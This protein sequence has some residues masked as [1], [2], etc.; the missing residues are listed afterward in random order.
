MRNVKRVNNLID[1][2]ADTTANKDLVLVSIKDFATFQFRL[3]TTD[4]KRQLDFN[5][6]MPKYGFCRIN[7]CNCRD[8]NSVAS[9]PADALV[10]TIKILG[11]Q[12]QYYLF[13]CSDGIDW[14]SLL[15]LA[16]QTQIEEESCLGL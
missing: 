11:A 7:T 5:V 1:A 6:H 14:L 9:Q 10:K 2:L 13:S 15:D 16:K 8:F 3:L 12:N 4:E